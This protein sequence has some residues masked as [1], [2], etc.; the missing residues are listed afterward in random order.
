M[1]EYPFDPGEE[2]LDQLK[3]RLLLG[4]RVF[5]VGFVV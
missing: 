3:R 2:K 1:A 4:F 5:V